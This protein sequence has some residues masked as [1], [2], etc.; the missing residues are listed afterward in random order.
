[1]TFRKSCWGSTLKLMLCETGEHLPG[2]SAHLQ[3]TAARWCGVFW[4]VR[5]TGPRVSSCFAPFLFVHL[6]FPQTSFP[7]SKF[8]GRPW[9]QDSIRRKVRRSQRVCTQWK[10]DRV[11]PPTLMINW[12]CFPFFPLKIVMTEQNLWSWSPDK[13]PPSPQIAGF[14]E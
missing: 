8:A 7:L 9:G 6:C 3:I 11:W 5:Y 2:C 13:S 14:S 12:D 10:N 4:S 1:M